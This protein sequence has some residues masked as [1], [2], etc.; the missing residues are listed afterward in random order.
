MSVRLSPTSLT[1]WFTSGCPAQWNF[2]QHWDVLTPNS[3]L[4]VGNAVHGLLEGQFS[5]DDYAGAAKNLSGLTDEMWSSAVRIFQKLLAFKA[6]LGFTVLRNS[7]GEPMVE[8]KY[9]WRISPGIQYVC[10]VDFMGTDSEGQLVIVD[11]KS[12]LGNGWKDFVV[13]ESN[14]VVPQKLGFQSE[15]YLLIPP[16][17]V[18]Q[19]LGLGNDWPEKL[20]YLVG[21]ARGPCQVF[22]YTKDKYEYANFKAALKLAAQAIEDSSFPK[23]KGKACFDCEF[24]KLCYQTFGVE[25][26]YAARG[27]RKGGPAPDAG[28]H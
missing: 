24:N 23:V 10:K 5:T 21:P 16:K 6:D 4:L 27:A 20:Y 11:Y 8:F 13:G 18:R 7:R 9:E 19:K 15:S 25:Q 22:S 12:T 28:R 14:V 3:H 17:A 2:S 26:L 1:R